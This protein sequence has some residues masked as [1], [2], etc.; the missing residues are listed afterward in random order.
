MVF[1]DAIFSDIENVCWCSAHLLRSTPQPSYPTGRVSRAISVGSDRPPKT[2][3]QF[4]SSSARITFFLFSF[5][6]NSWKRFFLLSNTA[7][8]TGAQTHTRPVLITLDTYSPA[9][10]HLPARLRRLNWKIYGDYCRKAIASSFRELNST[11]S[12]SSSSRFLG[13]QH[14]WLFFIAKHT[15]ELRENRVSS[16]GAFHTREECERKNSST[17]TLTRAAALGGELQALI[18]PQ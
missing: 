7:T 5:R 8:N 14:F 12:S 10:L 15:W 4:T 18:S 11:P 13:L 9:N 6:D 1:D 16:V 3:T 17:L 2:F